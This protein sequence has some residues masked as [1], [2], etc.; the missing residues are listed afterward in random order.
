MKESTAKGSYISSL[1]ASTHRRSKKNSRRKKS[2][3]Q[4]HFEINLGNEENN[5]YLDDNYLTEIP[6]RKQI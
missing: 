6:N 3:R 2:L 4:N 5:R 1:N